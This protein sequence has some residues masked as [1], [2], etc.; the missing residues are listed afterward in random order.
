MKVKLII[1]A[2]LM[3]ILAFAQYIDEKEARSIA[4]SVL[5]KKAVCFARNAPNADVKGH[6]E[7]V[8]PHIE[9]HRV[10]KSTNSD[11]PC[12]Y[13]YNQ[14]GG[15]G[16]FA[17]VSKQGQLLA[18]SNRGSI[19]Y[20]N[21]PVNL[22]W[23]LGQYQKI[24]SYGSPYPQGSE[25][26]KIEGNKSLYRKSIEPL[27][28]SE[29]SQESPFNNLI[30]EKYEVSGAT[31]NTDIVAGCTTIAMAQTMFKWKHPKKGKGSRK[32]KVGKTTYDVNFEDPLD[33]D[34]IGPSPDWKP[35]KPEALADLSYRVAASL[36][37]NVKDGGTYAYANNIPEALTTYFDYDASIRDENGT[38]LSADEF[39]DLAYTELECGRPC[40][41]YGQD[42][43]IP[44]FSTGHT[45][46]VEG[47]DAETNH[48]YINMG[49]GSIPEESEPANAYYALTV[50]NGSYYNYVVFQHIITHIKPNQKGHALPLIV[51]HTY[52]SIQSTRQVRSRSVIEYDNEINKTYHVSAQ[53]FS[54]DMD[55]DIV[56]GVIA[57]D[58]MTG[59]ECIF[60]GPT[61]YLTK[62][63]LQDMIFDI[64]L[65]KIEYNGYYQLRPVF[66]LAGEDEWFT[67]IIQTQNEEELVERTCVDV[68]NAKTLDF[69]Q[70]IEFTLNRT[71]I[72]P[73]IPLHIEYKLPIKGVS[74]T[75]TSSD[76]S[77]V[78]VDDNGKV[79]AHKEGEVTI[80]AHCDDYIFNGNRLVKE[81]TKQ[82]LITSEKFTNHQIELIYL[83]PYYLESDDVIKIVNHIWLT[84]D[85]AKS[86]YSKEIE[87]T[88]GYFQNGELVEMGQF[89]TS[90]YIMYNRK[91]QYDNQE[92]LSYNN[93]IEGEYEI[94]LIYRIPGETP[95]GE[96]WIMPSHREGEARVFMK[97]ENGHAT[98]RQIN[99]HPCELQIDAVDMS[100]V[101]E[102]G[103]SSTFTIN[104]SRTSELSYN[105][106]SDLFFYVD[107]EYRGYEELDMQES[108]S[109]SYIVQ[110]FNN[111]YNFKPDHV[112]TYNIKIFDGT[113]H[114][115]H[116]DNI[117][118]EE[119]KNYQLR[120]NNAKFHHSAY[121]NTVNEGVEIELELENIG[122][123][124]YK[125]DVVC[126]PVIPSGQEDFFLP[127]RIELDL[128]PG[129]IVKKVLPMNFFFYF[130]DFNFEYIIIKCYYTSNGEDTVLWKSEEL[131][132]TDPSTNI[133]LGDANN[134]GKVN[135]ADIVYVVSFLKG[136]VLPGFNEKAADAD[137]S[138]NISE[139]DISEIKNI[140]LR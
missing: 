84:P 42:S 39:E 40:I 103:I 16:G 23:L 63:Y 14:E 130:H 49:W 38:F 104:V 17:I 87:Y 82:F 96:F 51:A 71:T 11:D 73:G 92:Y 56:T 52:N 48:F 47:Y 111:A 75:F 26:D 66:R 68:S 126:K 21:A 90:E 10:V 139:V 110:D 22:K 36:D 80:T 98:F 4:A 86:D 85:Y 45:M 65:S 33:W 9:L 2:L 121:P 113:H 79:V 135:A 12:F 29:W 41:I 106:K 112:G 117:E 35:S 132:Y 133:L 62:G 101:A 30:K 77:I 18:H 122:E 107:G 137:L 19:N 50:K 102:V 125:G 20:D 94:R 93:L 67:I 70:I 46:V 116:E 91:C 89:W 27:I 97:L 134:D 15:D 44:L 37:S 13:I 60:E 109:K 61:L 69:S 53:I 140:I 31:Y 127:P 8:E 55:A 128:A 28:G 136:K 100:H 123:Y 118:V 138:G 43:W 95:E 58:Y 32:W 34:N 5:K 120:V 57:K 105:D 59:K 88:L 78:S 64:D 24:L 76:P 129:E 124:K 1:I 99:K 72:E 115:L 81:T 83:F 74:V 7:L 54:D 108:T 3:P 119:A 6:H 131:A 25:S 114:L